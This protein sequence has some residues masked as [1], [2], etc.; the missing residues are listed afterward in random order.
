VM[1]IFRSAF[2]CRLTPSRNRDYTHGSARSA[3]V[4]MLLD[5]RIVFL[6]TSPVGI[7]DPVITDPLA[8]RPSATALPAIREPHAG[9]YFYI[10]SPGG[11]VTSTLAH[12]RHDAVPRMPHLDL[13]RRHAAS[14]AAI[15]LTAALTASVM[16]AA[17]AHHAPSSLGPDRRDRLPTSISA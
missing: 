12:L 4:D 9:D 16:S 15:L 14:G 1:D 8:T 6:G 3:I 13:L 17:L 5:N 10:Q 11:N 7:F 2:S